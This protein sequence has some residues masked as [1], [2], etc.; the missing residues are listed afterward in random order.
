MGLPVTAPTTKG[1]KKNYDSNFRRFD[2]FIYGGGLLFFVDG[3]F[4]PVSSKLFF[5]QFHDLFFGQNH[6]S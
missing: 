5:R 1:D 2:S 6:P 3:E 4:L